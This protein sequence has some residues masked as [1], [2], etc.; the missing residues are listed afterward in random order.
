MTKIPLNIPNLLTFFRFLLIPPAV[1][2]VFWGQ[3]IIALILFTVA[4]VTDVLDGFIARKFNMVSEAGILLD[5]LADKAM[6][7]VMVIALTVQNVYPVFVAVII[8]LKEGLMIVGGIVL[9]TRKIVEPSNFV[10]KAAALFFNIAL[11]L[12]LLNQYVGQ[13]YLFAMYVALGLT[14]VAFMQYAYL[15]VIRRIKAKKQNS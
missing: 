12:A 14:V 7:V 5:P 13:W 11:G 2:C 10:G 15:N 8:F 6:A 4:C 9:Y 3:Y 1:L